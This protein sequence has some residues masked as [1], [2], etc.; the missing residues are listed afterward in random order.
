VAE[1]K[2]AYRRVEKLEGRSWRRLENNIKTDLKEIL[3]AKVN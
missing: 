2:N 3:Y 1:M